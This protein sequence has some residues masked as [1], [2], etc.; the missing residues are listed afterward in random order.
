MKLALCNNLTPLMGI[1][2]QWND[3]EEACQPK[4]GAKKSTLSHSWQMHGHGKG[5]IMFLQ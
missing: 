1:I 4:R 5:K 2:N 3:E